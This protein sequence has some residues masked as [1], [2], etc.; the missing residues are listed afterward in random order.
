M[1]M[2]GHAHHDDML[3]LGKDPQPS[4]DYPP[5]DRAGLREPRART[6][7]GP[8]A[9]RFALY[10]RAARGRAASS[11]P[12]I[13]IASSAKPRR[14]SRQQARAVID[15]PWPEPAQAGVGVFANEQPRVHVEVLDPTVRL[16][17][18]HYA[19]GS[20]VCGFSRTVEAGAAVRP[21]G[22]H[23]SRSGDARRRRRAASRSAR[24]RL[25]RGRRRQLRQRVPAAAAAAEGVRRSHHQLAARR[26]RRARRLRRRG[27]RRAAADRRDA[28]QRL[29]RD[30]L[31]SAREQRREDPLSLGRRAC[32]WWCACRGA[33]CATPARITRRTPSRGST[34]RRV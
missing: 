9:I 21:E 18:G 4:W 1:R 27:A 24:V 29:R 30:R 34:A 8:R 28:V 16:K 32:R 33:G 25:R 20:A 6:S 10:A 19:D 26:R 13:S 3:Y 2:C 17:R 11:T 15:A 7:T 31:Q 14:S 22:P 5:L 23:L 12:A